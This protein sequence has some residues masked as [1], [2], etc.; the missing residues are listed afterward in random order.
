MAMA[1]LC[2]DLSEVISSSI[3]MVLA[4]SH[5]FVR[6]ALLVIQKA[7]PPIASL[8]DPSV[9]ALELSLDIRVMMSS[10][11]ESLMGTSPRRANNSGGYC[12]I[13]ALRIF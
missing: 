8:T 10:P 9:P 11:S 2:S 6:K 12:E 1:P 3:P 13:V 5:I 7:W 4:W